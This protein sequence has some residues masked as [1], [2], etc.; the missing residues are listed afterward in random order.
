MD[1]RKNPYAPGAGTIPPELVG[2][3]ILIEK[4]SIA[5]DRCRNGLSSRGFLFVGLRGVGKTVLLARMAREAEA[6][7]FVT[8]S[9]ETPEKR[10]LPSLIVPALRSALLKLDR[11]SELEETGKRMLRVLGSFVSVMKLKYHDVEFGL[12]LGKEEGVAD[13][14]DLDHDLLT[15]FVEVG[16][17]AQKRKT[18]FAL[19][20]DEIQYLEEDQFASLI[21]ALHKCSQHQ[22]PVILIGAGLPQLVARAGKAKSYAERLFEY[23]EI[24]PLTDLDARE[25]IVS[26]AKKLDVKYEDDA[27]VEILKHT[28]AYP[29]FLQEWG[30]HSW[31]CASQSPITKEDVKVATQIAISELDASFFRVRFDRLTP[32]EKKYMRAM[33]ESSQRSGDIAALLQREVQA[34]APIRAS[35]IRKGMIYSKSHGDNHFTVPLFGDF[36]KRV[37]PVLIK[38]E[39]S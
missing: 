13:S 10:S 28:Q 9:I 18:A 24:G 6:A 37:M 32:G 1:P 21:M 34:V 4:V 19:F 17:A 20:I 7:G 23:P 27:L 38:N 31:A 22:L 16:K 2:R 11:V 25:A 30:Q 12:D 39:A 5:L 14:G 26:P 33:A 29:Y 3:D 35:L 8:V 15:L 36:M